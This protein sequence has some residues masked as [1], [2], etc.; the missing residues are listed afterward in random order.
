VGLILGS[1][2]FSFHFLW[3]LLLW[4]SERKKRHDGQVQLSQSPSQPFSILTSTA[5]N[6]SP[7]SHQFDY[8]DVCIVGAGPAGATCSYYLAKAGLKVILFDKAHFP[9][10]KVCGGTKHSSLSSHDSHGERVSEWV[11]AEMRID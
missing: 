8:Y 1:V 10:D 4:L 5:V 11:G 3:R 2:G 6:A 9:R 7:L